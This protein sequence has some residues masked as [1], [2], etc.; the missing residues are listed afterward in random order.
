M[1]SNLPTDPMELVE[2]GVCSVKFIDCMKGQC[3][4]CPG[5]GVVTNICEELEKVESLSYYRWV[6][7]QKT[8]HK[9]QD[10]VTGQ[11]VAILLADLVDGN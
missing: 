2:L 1:V 8:V 4:K 9:I 6:S 7:H 11:E 10:E 3:Y 5:K